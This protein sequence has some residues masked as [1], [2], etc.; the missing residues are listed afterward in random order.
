[1]PATYTISVLIY[2]NYYNQQMHNY[3]I[4]CIPQQSL[5]VIYIPTCFDTFVS[6]SGSLQATPYLVRQCL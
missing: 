3:I 5:C 6:S 1:M 2:S 4:K